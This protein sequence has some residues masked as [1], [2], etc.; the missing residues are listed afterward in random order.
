MCR[1]FE[2][3]AA[4]LTMPCSYMTHLNICTITRSPGPPPIMGS[5]LNLLYSIPQGLHTNHINPSGRV[6]NRSVTWNRAINQVWPFLTQIIQILIINSILRDLTCDAAQRG[7][8][9]HTAF[10]LSGLN[11]K[12][13]NEKYSPTTPLF[14]CPKVTCMD[15]DILLH[16]IIIYPWI[17]MERYFN[18]YY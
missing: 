14:P 12:I 3:R 1:Q 6:M 7:L 16:L 5:A 13:G 15:G 11:I 9:N 8:I 10:I 17:R 4:K 18:T 2:V